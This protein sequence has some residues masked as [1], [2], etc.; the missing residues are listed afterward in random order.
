MHRLIWF[1]FQTQEAYENVPI[2][3]ILAFGGQQMGIVNRSKTFNLL[4][5]LS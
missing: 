5:F 3:K 1:I 4:T 2:G